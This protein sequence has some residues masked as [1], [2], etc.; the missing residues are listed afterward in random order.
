M[1]RLIATLR[2]DARLQLRNGFYYASAFVLAIYA[3][4]LS[5]L[6]GTGVR[7]A[8]LVPALVLNNLAITSF[9]F[10]SGQVMLEKIEGSLS[11]QVVTP[12]RAG[13]YI[14][15]KTITLTLL[16]LAYNLAIVVLLIGRGVGPGLVLGI[17]AAAAIYTLFG[18]TAVARYTT[19]NEYLIPSIAY[20]G[21]LMLPILP[22]ML[23]WEHPLLYLHPIQAAL[24]LMRAASE[25]IGA[26]QWAYGLLYSL[27]WIGL[28]YWLARRAFRRHIAQ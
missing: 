6:P 25:P 23:G 3:L 18:I 2:T 24:V 5:Q 4:A 22:Y 14:A 16:S 13:E 8:W 11:A 20:I 21:G 28:A 1:N 7:L 10:A 26:G 27:L 12:L 17:A 15:S 9:Y 19:L